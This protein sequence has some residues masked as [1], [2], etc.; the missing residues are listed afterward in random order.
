MQAGSLSWSPYFT[1]AGGAGMWDEMNNC[2]AGSTFS[3]CVSLNN[4]YTSNTYAHTGSQNWRFYFGAAPSGSGSAI[5]QWQT[6][7]WDA[8]STFT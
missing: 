6:A 3:G 4:S 2:A 1:F 7:G 8:G 5:A